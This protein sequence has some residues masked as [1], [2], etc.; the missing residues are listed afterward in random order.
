[1]RGLWTEERFSFAGEHYVLQDAQMEPKPLQEHLPL[2][3]GGSGEKRTLRIVAEHGDIWN[4]F[5]G[6]LETFEH[7]LNVLSQ[8]CADVGRDPKEIT[9]SVHLRLPDNGD[10]GAMVEEAAAYADAGMDLGIVYLPPPHTPAVL[11][12]V[13]QALR[14][15]AG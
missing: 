5:F 12:P 6:D 14:P 7:K 1:M 9:T 3:I 10:P 11:E 15:L 2:V 13:A 4:T 8:H